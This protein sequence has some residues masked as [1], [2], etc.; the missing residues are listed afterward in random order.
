MKNSYFALAA[1]NKSSPNSN[2]MLPLLTT[3]KNL[4]LAPIS[5]G[6]AIGKQQNV[7]MSTVKQCKVLFENVC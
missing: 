6:L 4:F 2:E 1:I 3:W 5:K 7:F